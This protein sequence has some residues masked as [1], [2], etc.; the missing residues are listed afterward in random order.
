MVGSGVKLPGAERVTICAIDCANP[1]HAL[2]ALDISLS[3]MAF[4]DAVFLSDRASEY[5]LNGVRMVNIPRIE[6]GQGYSRFVLKELGRHFNT[7]HVLLIQWDGYVLDPSAWR[8]EF[9]DFDYIGAPWGWYSDEHRVGNGGFSLRSGRLCEALGDPEVAEYHPEDEAIGRRYRPL[10]ESQHGI[11][12][13]PESLAARFSFEATYP[14]ESTFGFHGLFNMWMVVPR[15]GLGRFVAEL[16]DEVVAGPQYLR[17]ARNYWE[18]NRREEAVIT[19]QERTRRNGADTEATALLSVWQ[20]D[21]RPAALPGVGRN[22][23]CPCGSGKR[24]KACCGQ[25]GQP[26]ARA[27]AETVRASFDPR[28]LLD[29]A[30]AFHQ[31]GKLAE[32]ETIYRRVLSVA[33]DNIVAM[34]YLGV[35]SLQK[36]DALTAETMVRRAIASADDVPE[37]HSNLGLCLRAQGRLE[38]AVACY[39]RAISLRP[40]YA[41]AYSN[42]GLDLQALG[43]PEHAMAAFEDAIAADSELAEAHWNLGLVRLLLGRYRQAWAEYEWRLRCQAFERDRLVLPGATPWQG[44]PLAGRTLLIRQEQGAGDTIQFM[45]FIPPLVGAAGRVIVEIAPFLQALARASLPGAV[46]VDRDGWKE[47][48]DFYVNLMSLPLQRAL[49]IEQ[50][51]FATR[52]VKA[53]PESASRWRDRLAGYRE[54][55]VGIA[56]AGN[57]AH[58]NDHNRSCPAEFLEPLLGVG[59]CSWFSLQK[60]RPLPGAWRGRVADLSEELQDFS[61]TAAAMQALDLVVAVDT[62]VAH[63]AGALGVPVWVMLP[64]APDWRWLVDRADSPWYP[65]AR[66]FRQPAP[67]D[68]GSVAASVVSA[69]TRLSKQ[70]SPARIASD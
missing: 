13:A 52:Y 54:L 11:R 58:A 35:L 67:G 7:S 15:D 41:G 42:L 38:E 61:D 36:G 8:A 22:D 16:S 19:L 66:L 69:L 28:A 1:V 24:Y 14:T 9:L 40:D 51:P 46:V 21:A 30:T 31:A 34:Q 57:P 23:P 12:F 47:P 18:L 56:W 64:F 17:L 45:R 53:E 3:R 59:G 33:P 6:S 44:E 20:S 37:F 10:L 5:A 29:Q 49:A 70:P 39:R 26:G 32:A 65:S 4:A 63:L 25:L 43:R 27:G 62:S 50:L 68:W 55:R 2:L 48:I 60:G